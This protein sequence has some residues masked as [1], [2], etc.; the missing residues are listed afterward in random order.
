MN[1]L[2][3]AMSTKYVES[4]A[5]VIKASY[6]CWTSACDNLS[7]VVLFPRKRGLIVW[8]CRWRRCGIWDEFR[9]NHACLRLSLLF[10][11]TYLRMHK[12]RHTKQRW[13]TDNTVLLAAAFC[14]DYCW[15]IDWAYEGWA[16]ALIKIEMFVNSDTKLFDVVYQWNRCTCNLNGS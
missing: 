3:R 7:I 13:R 5:R 12:W 4:E 15:R 2:T 8:K 10:S 16:Y 14:T 1:F 11:N 6:C 9:I